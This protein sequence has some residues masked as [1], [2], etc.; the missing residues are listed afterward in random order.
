MEETAICTVDEKGVIAYEEMVP[1]KPKLIDMCLKAKGLPI[2][3]ISYIFA[4]EKD[5]DE[6]KKW[7]QN[8]GN[9]SEVKSIEAMK[10]YL[11]IKWSMNR[12]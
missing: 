12:Y 7:V 1:T 3:K 2:E 4:P 6:I 9:N 8:V 11:D 10:L 5:I